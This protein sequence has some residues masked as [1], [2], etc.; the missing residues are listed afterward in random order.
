MQRVLA[1]GGIV[2]NEKDELLFIYKRSKWDFPKGHVERGETFEHCAI[3]EVIEETGLKNLRIIRFAGTTEHIYYDGFFKAEV[4]KEIRW[5]E[6]FTE[7]NV[8]LIA[9]AEESIE[10][11]RW[12]SKIE[13]SGYLLHSYENI[14]EILRQ[15]GVLSHIYKYRES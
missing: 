2:L 7:D 15:S 14:K 1:A 12:V 5:Y 4:I 3:R 6:M 13:I 8:P 11:I 10:W 9:Q